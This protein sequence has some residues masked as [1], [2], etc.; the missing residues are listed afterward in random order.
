M[1]RRFDPQLSSSVRAE[2]A[3]FTLVELMVAMTGGLFLSIVVFALSRDAS[4]FYQSE[5][6]AANAT[7]AG[8][9]GFERLSN[10]IAR[11][12]HLISPNITNDPRVCNR[13]ESTWP[14]KLFNLRAITLGTSGKITGTELAAA[15]I[16]P[17]AIELAGS[18]DVTEEL[19]INH[20]G[21]N[22]DG[23]MAVTLRDDTP[24]FR[25]LGLKTGVANKEHN[26][27]VLLS[28]FKPG[29]TGRAVR[30]TQLDGMEQYAIV[31]DV[32]SESLL[33]ITL[34]PDPK[35]QFRTSTASVQCGFR[36]FTTGGTINVINFI[37][38]ELRPMILA[39][40]AYAS[41]FDAS[42]H[43]APEYEKGRV[44]LVRFELDPEG[45]E[46]D[47]TLE[48]VSEYAVDLQFSVKQATSALN[49]ALIEPGPTTI[50]GTYGFTQWLRGVHVRFSVRSREADRQ[51]D[52][53]GMPA[54]DL[55]R[56][57]LG[58]SAGA[59]FARVRT[60]QADVPLRNLEGANW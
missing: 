32:I 13:P 21:P 18:L 51:A 17:M 57:G 14:V 1:A 8:V 54:G 34:R 60:F 5:T 19:P 22:A 28:L 52:V 39:P 53:T 10:D 3:G 40:G 11:A 47:N 7:L 4:R 23:A 35:L 30:I 12:G 37:R 50:T 48:I 25:R 58:A 45:D 26:K 31:A 55:Y 29:G 36:G 49:P 2:Q 27:A 42:G 43:G 15:G 56:I 59:P 16:Q 6:R 9:T 33:Q 20:V 46:M 41:L 38:Y 44:E 24:A